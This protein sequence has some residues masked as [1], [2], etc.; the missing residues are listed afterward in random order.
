MSVLLLS[1]HGL[2]KKDGLQQVLVA[3]ILFNK[4]SLYMNGFFTRN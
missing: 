3:S 1:R 2:R 4:L